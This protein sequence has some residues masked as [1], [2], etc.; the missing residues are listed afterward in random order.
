[1]PPEPDDALAGAVRASFRFLLI[2]VGAV[3][4]VWSVSG[5]R[6]VQPGEQ[7]VVLRGGAAVRSRIR[8]GLVLAL[9]AP[10]ERVL[11]LPAAERQLAATVAWRPVAALPADQP[12]LH[13]RR[14]GSYLVVGDGAVLHATAQVQWSVTEPRLHALAVAAPAAALE[15]VVR[16][17]VAATCAGMRLDELLYG[18][19]DRAQQ[20]AR[21][22]AQLR[23][24]RQGLGVTIHRIELALA[25]PGRAEQAFAQAQSAGAEASTQ[26]AQGET[27]ARQ[28]LQEA[29]READRLRQAATAAAGEAVARARID[30]DPIA[31]QLDVGLG[32][33]TADRLASDGLAAALESC[34]RVLVVPAGDGASLL[35]PAVRPGA[36]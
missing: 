13:P 24:D 26:V 34:G 8:P 31:A 30:T 20:A 7:A 2:A 11:V 5:I 21:G 1:M 12:G 15:R 32:A 17:A 16:A 35:L 28:V 4:A 29:N 3:L 14:D 25:L 27:S 22:A 10:L 36:R 6:Q 19:L 23:C 18:G 33:G 9:P